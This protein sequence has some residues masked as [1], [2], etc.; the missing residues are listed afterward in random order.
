MN[1]SIQNTILELGN[2]SKFISVICATEPKMNKKHREDKTPN[3]Y[4][5]RIIKVS[6]M[7]FHINVDYKKAVE[8]RIE[9]STG[10]KT[11]YEVKENYFEHI[12]ECKAITRHKTKNKFYLNGIVTEVKS[13][14]FLRNENGRYTEIDKA[15]LAPYFP[16]KKKS[17][18][19][20]EY[21]AISLENIARIKC[22]DISW[23][24]NETDKTK[25]T[26]VLEL[27]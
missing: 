21:R 4:L 22:G 7:S 14:Y 23:K 16:P 3:P 6:R 10:E 9:K 13:K 19:K 17:E 15:Q 18:F 5:D 25:E 1:S 12:P 24:V 11:D 2:A 27:V 8:K 26:S 20:P